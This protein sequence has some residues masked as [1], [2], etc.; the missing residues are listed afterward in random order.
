MAKA[1]KHVDSYPEL[2]D[3]SALQR[4][5]LTEGR[6]PD[7]LPLQHHFSESKYTR[8]V[9]IPKG[10]WVVG[11]VHREKTLNI[12]MQGE[13]LYYSG[14]KKQPQRLKAPAVFE[15]EAGQR[16]IVVAL[17]NVVFANVHVTDETDLVK[18][19]KRFIIPEHELLESDHDPEKYMFVL[20]KD[21]TELLPRY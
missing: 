20:H 6:S 3:A 5:L 1:L 14:F 21:S 11:K 15:S 16:K 8:V 2:A 9:K 7:E 13:L 19:E 4:I 12:L 18:L 17:S 10:Y